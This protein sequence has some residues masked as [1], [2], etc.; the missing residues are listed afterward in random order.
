[1][2]DNLGWP[3]FIVLALI[4]LFIF[5]PERLPKV[6]GEAA[7]M[8]RTLRRLT[9][10]A[11]AELRQEMGTDFEFE[12][13]HPKRFVRKHLLS[14]EDEEALRRPLRDAMSDFEELAHADD[15]TEGYRAAA[16]DSAP[17]E[18]TRPRGA[19]AHYDPDAT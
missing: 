1:V 5:G 2:F 15:V 19:T 7:N 13:L 3:E 12:D 9:N 8:L 17:I 4:G 11:T 18:H 14:E 10:N 6:I 16:T